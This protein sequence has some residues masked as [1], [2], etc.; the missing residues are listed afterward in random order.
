MTVVI[1]E[2][3]LE[4]VTSGYKASPWEYETE[5]YLSCFGDEKFRPGIPPRNC[6][7]LSWPKLRKLGSKHR[8]ASL[9]FTLTG[10]GDTNRLTDYVW[11]GH[12]RARGADIVSRGIYNTPSTPAVH[13][14]CV[15]FPDSLK[16]LPPKEV[17]THRRKISSFVFVVKAM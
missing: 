12:T 11:D 5:D 14:L 6:P 1:L 2:A 17:D 7:Q 15:Y 8:V 4:S 10:Y 9:F 16:A 3:D 13:L